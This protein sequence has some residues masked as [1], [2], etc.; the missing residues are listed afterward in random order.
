VETPDTDKEL[1]SD[2]RASARPYHVARRLQTFFSDGQMPTEAHS[3]GVIYP[4]LENE[5]SESCENRQFVP[6][7]DCS[8]PVFDEI[9]RSVTARFRACRKCFLYSTSQLLARAFQLHYDRGGRVR[10]RTRLLYHVGIAVFCLLLPVYGGQKSLEPA[11]WDKGLRLSEAPDINPDPNIVEVNLEAKIAEV[12]VGGQPVRVWTYSGGIPGPLIRAKVGDRL[13]VHF[14]NNLPAPTTVHWHGI[15]VPIEMDGVPDISQPAVE[16]G[17]SFTYDFV[18]PDAGL[19]WYHPHVQS[20]AQVGYGLSGPLL[21]EDPSE[22]IGVA[23]QLVLVLN[24]LEIDHHGKL[25]SAD[26]GGSSGMA[27]GRE[28]NVVLVNGKK[29]PPLIARAGV[30]QRW[31]IVNTAKSRYFDID[32]TD[33]TVLTKIGGD[34]GLQEYPNPHQTLVL[35]PGE[36][37]DVIVTFKSKPGESFDVNSDLFNRG[38]GSV[39][40]RNIET[41]IQVKMVD[42]PAYKALPLREIRREIRPPSTEGATPVNLKLEVIQ[43]ANREFHYLI[44]GKPFSKATPIPAKLGETQI[45]N[46][47]NPSPWSHPLHIHGFFFLVLDRNGEP[48]HPMEWKDTVSV[49][50]KDSL[51]LLVRFEDRPGTWMVHCHIL[52]H[53]EGGLMTTV[54]VG[55]GPVMTHSHQP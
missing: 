12:D 11:D 51:K 35:A 25:A 55:N 23:D 10:M 37:A 1:P 17:K 22:N 39:E 32:I 48:V 50:L 42:L 18:V 20:A 7:A 9:A 16:P 2:Y 5:F 13:I 47:D 49:P 3:C 26:S 52:D 27:F 31:R 4:K 6:T 43:D 29:A 19:F 8:N 34:G 46:V 41:L 30:P 24:D 36:R 45:W 21:V 53:A 14:T 33:G 15:R 44:N 38:Y 40:F 28:G 54:Q